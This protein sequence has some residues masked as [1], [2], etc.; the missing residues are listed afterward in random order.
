MTANRRN[1]VLLSTG[2]FASAAGGSSAA[3]ASEVRYNRPQVTVDYLTHPR[4]TASCGNC[5]LFRPASSGQ[6]QGCLVV[7]SPIVADGSC[8]LHEFTQ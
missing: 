5:K 6:P 7:A 8:V 2:A 4:G 1:V 3:F